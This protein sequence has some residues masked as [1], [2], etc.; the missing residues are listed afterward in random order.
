MMARLKNAGLVACLTTAA[1]ALSAATAYAHGM[2]AEYLNGMYKASLFYPA[3]TKGEIKYCVEVPEGDRWSKASVAAQVETSMR[4]W[5]N[6]TG[7]ATLSRVKLTQVSCKGREANLRLT[8]G[9]TETP[10]LDFLGY[11]ISRNEN[12]YYY[13]DLR[14][15]TTR[16]CSN[17]ADTR[18]R[19][20]QDTGYLMFR[21]SARDKNKVARQLEKM[22]SGTLEGNA[23]TVGLMPGD[24]LC[25]THLILVHEMGHA[26]GMCDTYGKYAAEQ[27]A[28]PASRSNH[29]K[30]VMQMGFSF[31]LY[32]DDIEGIREVYEYV[33]KQL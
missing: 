6:A 20:L 16:V 28:Y 7:D 30:S 22:S 12:G 4:V 5:M 1:L 27:C 32:P 23:S 15:N 3:L 29:P 13:N 2:K 33:R 9:V 25:S 31:N 14:L 11:Q 26:F 18:A 8:I 19:V 21:Q 10:D 24:L 17:T